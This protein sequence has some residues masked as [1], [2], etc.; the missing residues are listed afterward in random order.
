MKTRLAIAPPL[1]ALVLG[2][3]PAHAG[4]TAFL[5]P[6]PLAQRALAAQPEVRAAVAAAQAT[7]ADS[8]ALAAGS[9]EW[10]AQLIPQRR[11][12]AP[13]L[14]YREF[15]GQ[16]SRRIRLPGKAAL[17]RAIGQHADIA[18]N[19]RIDD[20]THQAARRLG[21]DWMGWLRARL[22]DADTQ[23]QL[24]LMRQARQALARRVQLGDAAR[25][26]LD[27]MDAELA[28]LQAEALRTAS[29]AEAARK[30][31]A[32]T[33]PQLPLPAT[34]PSLPDPAPLPGGVAYWRDLIIARSHEIGIAEQDALRQQQVA[35]RAR[36]DRRPDPSIG[37]RVLDDRGGAERAV[38]VVLSV[39]LGGRY[40]RDVAARE[41][42]R[43]DMAQA[44]VDGMRLSIT[45]EA[46]ATAD[47]AEARHAQWQA[48]Q[49]AATAQEAAA[50]RTRRAWELGEAPLAEWLLAQRN[51]RASRSQ[52]RQA[53]VDALEAALL[54]RIDSHELWHDNEDEADGTP[55]E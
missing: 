22:L 53:R 13:D 24:E 3:L 15:E 37:L 35:A 5:P 29:E 43:A 45:R 44:D 25:R 54:V 26:E 18:A 46:Q 34:P 39:P 6:E 12:V 47:L 52:E 27:T 28:Q 40:R 17:D 7:H 10:E 23:A 16:I 19:L 8:R 50:A 14:R 4:D 11:S 36:A 42:A 51:A 32:V 49:A 31:L 41:A 20:A 1:L 38:G 48:L 30:A 33:Y 9:Y 55:R 2:A 21:H